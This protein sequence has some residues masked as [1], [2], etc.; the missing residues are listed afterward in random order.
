[1]SSGRDEFVN[2]LI[3]YPASLRS[4]LRIMRL[5]A[6]GA[7]IG[8]HCTV[9]KGM[10][11]RNPWDLRMGD[12]VTLDPYVVLLSTGGRQAEPRL[13]FGSGI[14]CNRF[15]MFD[16]CQRLEVQDE[17]MIGPHCYITDHDHGIEA[18]KPVWQQPMA[19]TPTTICRGAWIGA[20]AM[21]L[22]GVTVG[23]GAIVAAGAIVTQDVEP[24]MIVAGVPARV[25]RPR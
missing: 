3:R 19:S 6:L 23:E 9:H 13:I 10:L 15:T 16:A 12:H 8:R 17:V 5:R 2:R 21:V 20:G 4:R 24:G 14:Y 18:G 11:P 7:D 25:I 22:R 1:M